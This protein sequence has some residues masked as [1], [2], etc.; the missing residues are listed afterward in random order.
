MS[1]LS[2]ILRGRALVA[3]ALTATL[4]ACQ[5]AEAPSPPGSTRISTAAFAPEVVRVSATLSGPILPQL[6]YDL[7]PASDGSWW[8]DVPGLPAGALH[9]ELAAF[10]AAGAERFHGR[11]DATVVA[12]GVAALQVF[13]HEVSPPPSYGNTP[14]RIDAIGVSSLTVGVGGVISLNVSAS[15]VDAGAVLS[16]LWRSS[17]GSFSDPAAPVTQWTAPTAPGTQSIFVTVRDEKGASMDASFVVTVVEVAPT[18]GTLALTV[19]LNRAPLL[20]DLLVAPS[21]VLPGETTTVVAWGLDPDGDAMSLQWVSEC[22]GAFGD[23]TAASTTFTPAPGL[24]GQLCFLRLFADDGNGGS[25]TAWTGVWVGPPPPVGPIAPPPPPPPPPGMVG[26]V[27]GSFENGDY[28]GWFLLGFPS[29][30]DSINPTAGGIWGVGYAGEPIDRFLPVLDYFS[31]MVVPATSPLLPI[32]IQPTDGQYSAFQI[33]NGLGRY[34]LF[35]QVTVEP[36]P[37][38]MPTFATFTLSAQTL[39]GWQPGLQSVAVNIRDPSDRIVA[40]PFMTSAAFPMGGFPMPISIDMTPYRGQTVV[41]DVEIAA[42]LE[43][44]AVQ[45][46]AFQLR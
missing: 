42:Q 9:V 27:N 10:D 45:L 46:D 39:S 8:I 43:P 21:R 16:F 13:A 7:A 35:Q 34:R 14:P 38:G 17:S 19:V 15:D 5:P 4:V 20:T 25:A 11:G 23:P 33:P 31:W 24:P 2:P 41:F 44:I 18:E 1:R 37:L 22:P 12:G 6:V 30:P 26:F 29:Q 36:D 32:M 3:A 40:T 28:A